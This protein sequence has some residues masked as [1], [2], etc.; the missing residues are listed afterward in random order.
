M[1][2][3]NYSPYRN[4]VLRTPGLSIEELESLP[5]DES[6]IQEFIK[7]SWQNPLIRNAVLLAS[8]SLAEE[9]DEILNIN[10][11]IPSGLYWS[12][13]NYFIRFCTR[14]TPFG[15]FAGVSSGLICPESEI[16]IRLKPLEKSQLCC[17][18]DM[19]Y[20]CATANKN[21]LMREVKEKLKYDFPASYYTIGNEFRYL[22]ARYGSGGAK[23][24]SLESIELTETISSILGYLT[25][26]KTFD[27]MVAGLMSVTSESRENCEAFLTDLIR[28]GTFSHDFMP[29]LTG[30]EFSKHLSELIIEKDLVH[31][32]SGF[33][34]QLDILEGNN[35][36]LEIEQNLELVTGIADTLDVPYHKGRI[37]QGDL[38]RGHL[39]SQIPDS[40][41]NKVLY[42]LR[43]MNALTNQAKIDPLAEFK[44]VFARRYGDNVVDFCEVMDQDIGIGL[45]GPSFQQQADPSDLLDNLSNY[46]SAGRMH[47]AKQ[48]TSLSS[49]EKMTTKDEYYIELNNNDLA[50]FSSE[51][52]AWPGQQYAI[53][54]LSGSCDDPEIIF[55]AA[56][57]GHP[58]YLLG[59]FGFL[60]D[61]GITGLVQKMIKDEE[62]SNPDKI[63]AEIVHLPEE[64]TGNVLQRPSTYRYE[65]PYMARSLKERGRQLR[66]NQLAVKIIND[67]VVL[68]HKETN[69]EVIP[70]LT[71][72]HNYEARQL[73]VY[74]FLVKCGLQKRQGSYRL[75]RIDQPRKGF[76]PGIRKGSIIFQLPRWELNL[77]SLKALVEKDKKN[78]VK[79]IQSWAS[80]IGMPEK[81][82]LKQSDRDLYVDW[83]KPVL[84]RNFWVNAM[85]ISFAKFEVFPYKHGS[86]I[87]E[88]VLSYANELVLCFHSEK[89]K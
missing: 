26:G 52:K 24:Y 16:D 45:L 67:R 75:D 77:D 87:K 8:P 40:L 65:I 46:G 6:G 73:P 50:P 69:K 20:V 74:E 61:P 55:R 15:L 12:F 17:R 21:I 37:I 85:R 19:E 11:V 79:V 39:S 27:Q 47:P 42:G 81:V 14:P 1:K 72:A 53:V 41:A 33:I 31:V 3:I 51:V 10:K 43:V 13:L 63:Y 62:D 59:R 28:T 36:P 34:K 71:N 66:I 2:R 7:T 60:P 48:L 56:G 82:V 18:L 49:R 64:R 78:L 76:I 68:L 80:S 5:D 58:A 32:F 25:T 30:C 44:R 57:E 70:C 35:N 38:L 23:E 9:L 84:I 29:N 88:E 22:N 89:I 4:F 83:T 54:S 86:P